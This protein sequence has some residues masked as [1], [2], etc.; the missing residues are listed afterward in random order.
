MLT[1]SKNENDLFHSC[2]NINQHFLRHRL[3]LEKDNYNFIPRSYLDVLKYMKS[4]IP[5]KWQKTNIKNCKDR[6]HLKMAQNNEIEYHISPKYRDFVF[7][8]RTNTNMVIGI[9]INNAKICSSNIYWEDGVLIGKNCSIGHYIYFGKNVTVSDFSTINNNSYIGE[10]SFIGS[11][12]VLKYK[13]YIGNYN[14]IDKNNKIGLF[15]DQAIDKNIIDDDKNVKY[16]ADEL[17]KSPFFLIIC[18]QNFFGK[19]GII[20]INT[21]IMSK[22]IFDSKYIIKSLATISDSNSFPRYF[23]ASE[24]S[25]NGYSRKYRENLDF[26]SK[27]RDYMGKDDERNLLVIETKNIFHEVHKKFNEKNTIVYLP[28][29]LRYKKYYCGNNREQEV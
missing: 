27:R 25:F 4:I 20:E 17:K 8:R 29:K 22:N 10:G 3:I 21:L 28:K 1:L 6:I 12:S 9:H 23:K 13:T 2:E 18:D 26:L 19:D 15:F 5:D 16:L 7:Y 14:I 11:N 24:C